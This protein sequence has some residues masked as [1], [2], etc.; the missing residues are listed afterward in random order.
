MDTVTLL[1]LTAAGLSVVSFT[2]QVYKTFKTKK[3][4]DLSLVMW[5]IFVIGAALWVVYG[6]LVEDLPILI[7]NASVFIMQSFVIWMILRYRRK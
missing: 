3:V 6:I 2:P 5:I 7:T 4:R 1:G